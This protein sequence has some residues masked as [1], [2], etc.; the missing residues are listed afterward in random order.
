MTEEVFTAN[1]ASVSIYEVVVGDY[2]SSTTLLFTCKYTQDVSLL[3][4]LTTTEEYQYGTDDIDIQDET[5]SYDFSMGNFYYSKDLEFNATDRT[6]KY[7]IVVTFENL[8]T[9][10]EDI[11][12]LEDCKNTMWQVLFRDNDTVRVTARFK[13]GK[14]S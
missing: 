5:Q 4:S 14:I 8:T 2:G 3:K 12:T 1:E 6:K 7:E 11:Y 9:A 10:Q 13:P